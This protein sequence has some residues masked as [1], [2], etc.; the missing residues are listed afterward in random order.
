MAGSDVKTALPS[1]DF[2]IPVLVPVRLLEEVPEFLPE[3]V[4]EELLVPVWVELLEE[5]WEELEDPV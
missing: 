5:F 2:V 1:L 4:D 3:V